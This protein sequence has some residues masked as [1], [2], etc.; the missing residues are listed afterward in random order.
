VAGAVVV[1][2]DAADR[3]LF[4]T[5]GR[6]AMDTPAGSTV[7]RRIGVM[8]EEIGMAKRPENLIDGDVTLRRALEDVCLVVSPGHRAT[9]SEPFRG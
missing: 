5:I 2:L 9:G 4:S 1:E 6:P 8:V 7:A 3:Q